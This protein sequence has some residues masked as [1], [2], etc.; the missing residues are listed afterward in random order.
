MSDVTIMMIAAAPVRDALPEGLELKERLLWAMR[1]V[2]NR[3]DG[4]FWMA[5]ATDDLMMKAAIAA[6]MQKA[7]KEEQDRID[8]SVRAL[9]TLGALLQGI[10]VDVLAMAAQ[11][12]EPGVLPLIGM[13]HESG[14][15]QA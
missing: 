2:R 6:V 3:K 13:W 14:K 8:R 1:E 15:E 5:P 11:V 4:L 10:P 7:T 12:E 9:A